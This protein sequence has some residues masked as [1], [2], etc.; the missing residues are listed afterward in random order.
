M[1]ADAISYELESDG[2]HNPDGERYKK[3]MT[4]CVHA[5]TAMVTKETNF[6]CRNV[7]LSRYLDGKRSTL[8]LVLPGAY[9]GEIPEAF[10]WE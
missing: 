4:V 7:R 2:H 10:P 9:T 6:V 3:G 8:S 5:P 1:F